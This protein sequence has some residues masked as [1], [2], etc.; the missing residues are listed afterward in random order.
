MCRH[1]ASAMGYKSPNLV[2]LRVTQR[3][4]IR[5]D[6][7]LEFRQMRRIQKLVVHHLKR[8]ARFN[9]R[10]IP[11]ERIILHLGRDLLIAVEPCRL[12]RIDQPH[13]RQRFAVSQVALILLRPQVESSTPSASAHRA[14]CH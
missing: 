14:E 6:E 11:A 10:L 12:L 5:Q 13:A 8:D 9:Q 4:N 2:A 7:S 1:Q 3:G